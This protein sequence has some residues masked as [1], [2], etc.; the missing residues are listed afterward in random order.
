MARKILIAIGLAVLTVLAIGMLLSQ[1][2]SVSRTVTIEADK[3]RIHALTGDL[4]RW[5]EW[6][7]WE[8][9]DK[10]I[11]K[12]LGPVTS[13]VGATQSWSSKNGDG[14]LEVKLSDPNEGVAWDIVFVQNGHESPARSWITYQQRG[15]VV[16]VMWT[17]EGE[18]DM[19]LLG[20]WFARF[21]DRMMGPMF[22]Q[23]LQ[24]LKTKAET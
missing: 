5:S 11:R 14:R 1:S 17:M 18:M 7:P 22:E 10:T 2:Y 23:G 12:S 21:A 15:D 9:D 16:D 3:A 20:G 13:G 8:Q 24:A 4:T 6:V 19:P